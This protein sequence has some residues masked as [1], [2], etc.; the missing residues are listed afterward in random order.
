MRRTV[1]VLLA[2]L[3]LFLAG[4]CQKEKSEI[5]MTSG[6]IAIKG[7]DPVA[8]FTEHEPVRGSE[9]YGYQW[10]GATWLFVNQAHLD[11]FKDDP[12]K[13]SPKYGGYCAYAVSQ[14]TLADIDPQSWDIVDGKLYLNLNKQVQGLWRKDMPGYIEKADKYWP[15]VL[16]K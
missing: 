14:D 13:Y 1:H 6:G 11:L 4:A 3:V 7:Y 15:N 8:Y 2:L 10:K 12:E 5:N 16:K 9:Q